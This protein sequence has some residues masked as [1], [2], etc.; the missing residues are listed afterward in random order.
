MTTK[1]TIKY[2]VHSSVVS[3][4]L[5]LKYKHL[6]SNINFVMPNLHVQVLINVQ[7]KKLVVMFVV[8]PKRN[9]RTETPA[10]VLTVPP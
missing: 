5:I 7:W 6:S 2:K 3:L 10:C 1:K 8:T 4:A 9:S